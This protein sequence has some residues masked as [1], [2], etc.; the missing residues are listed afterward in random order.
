M[1]DYLTDI[2]DDVEYYVSL[3]SFGLM[4]MFPYSYTKEHAKDHG[5]L[6]AKAKIGV[7]TIR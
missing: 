5:E 6:L 1:R 4:W 2:K 3:H 7:D